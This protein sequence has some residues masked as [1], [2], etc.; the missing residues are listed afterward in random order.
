MQEEDAVTLGAAITGAVASGAW[1][2]FPAACQAMVTPGEVIKANP[3]RQDFYTRKYQAYLT[4]WDQQQTLN[5]L[6]Q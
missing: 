5:Q 4:M 2:N 1:S 6:M 3:Q